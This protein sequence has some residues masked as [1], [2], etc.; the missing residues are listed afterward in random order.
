MICLP[1]GEPVDDLNTG[2]DT[3]TNKE[4]EESANLRNVIQKSHSGLEQE[5]K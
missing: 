2:N 5:N 4:T 1:E 3:E